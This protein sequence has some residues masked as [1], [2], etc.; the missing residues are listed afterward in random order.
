MKGE[1]L[2]DKQAELKTEKAERAS[3]GNQAQV[4]VD[5]KAAEAE[6]EAEETE[7]GNDAPKN[8]PPTPSSAAS[9]FATT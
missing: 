8:A 6:D 2:E 4:E 7:D 5:G 1:L 9:S 3:A